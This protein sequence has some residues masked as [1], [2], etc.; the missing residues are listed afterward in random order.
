[1]LFRTDPDDPGSADLSALEALSD[2]G[3]FLGL[4]DVEGV[5]DVSGWLE[6]AGVTSKPVNSEFHLYLACACDRL[7]TGSGV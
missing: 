5:Q 6:D 3:A 1:M 7:W 2:L 4:L